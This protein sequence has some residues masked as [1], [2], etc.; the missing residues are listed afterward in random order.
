MLTK[1]TIYGYNIAQIWVVYL[2]KAC[3]K[4][5]NVAYVTREVV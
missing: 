4:H 3:A 5:E 2:H 1:T